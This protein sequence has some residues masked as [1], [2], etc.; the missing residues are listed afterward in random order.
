M[1]KVLVDL[2]DDLDKKI[3]IR[4]IDSGLKNKNETIVHILEDS[5]NE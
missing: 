4:M 3:K 2:D 1:V 5:L